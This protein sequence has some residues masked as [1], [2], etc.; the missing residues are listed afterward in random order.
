MLGFIPTYTNGQTL[1]DDWVTK[2]GRVSS[3]NNFSSMLTYESFRAPKHRSSNSPSVAWH[4]PPDDCM[5]GFVY[6]I[7]QC[8]S[9]VFVRPKCH[10][11]KSR[12]E[13][14]K[15][16]PNQLGRNPTKQK[17]TV[18]LRVMR[19]TKGKSCRSRHDG[20]TLKVRLQKN[21][22]RPCSPSSCPP[23]LR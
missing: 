6:P 14:R 21:D 12:G 1:N 15:T 9:F 3:L 20:A 8:Y 22:P 17:H 19:C 7:K 5:C 10:L 11:K 2:L 16:R 23:L 4:P 18:T 13:R